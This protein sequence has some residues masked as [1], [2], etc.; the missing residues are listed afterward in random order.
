MV[1]YGCNKR[2]G[3]DME[4]IGDGDWKCPKCG[5]VI[6]FGEPDEEDDDNGESIN[7]WDAA[8]IYASQGFDED[9]QFGYTH[10]ELMKALGRK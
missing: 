4:Y 5:S 2:C 1:S 8:D 7:V 3:V 6:A 10:E 9:Y